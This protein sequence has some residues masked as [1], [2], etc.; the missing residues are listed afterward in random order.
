MRNNKYNVWYY[1]SNYKFNS[2]FIK[3]LFIIFTA[4][5]LPL[6]AICLGLYIY[7][8]GAFLNEMTASEENGLMRIKEIVD[9]VQTNILA[10]GTNLTSDYYIEHF[11]ISEQWDRPSYD[12]A[13]NIYNAIKTI[14]F[15]CGEYVDSIYIYS[16]NNKYVL[17]KQ[18][19]SSVTTFY[20]TLWLNSYEQ[21]RTNNVQWSWGRLMKTPSGKTLSCISTAF[22][23]PLVRTSNSIYG[24]VIVNLSGLWLDKLLA[25]YNDNDFYIVDYQG[26]ILYNQDS[27]LLGMSFEETVGYEL[28]RKESKVS[29][30]EQELRGYNCIRSDTNGWYYVMISGLSGY[31]EKIGLLNALI[32]TL[33]SVLLLLAVV[34]SYFISARVFLPIKN[35]MQMI[36]DPKTFYERNTAI[37]QDNKD[38]YNE[39][40]YIATS[41]LSSFSKTEQTE[42]ELSAISPS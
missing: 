19:P 23:M 26:R 42:A 9:T 21:N 1:F 31:Q 29:Y 28:K 37:T 15:S 5:Y 10:A 24:V 8:K 17:S 35:I 27:G 25:G 30:Y 20:D 32:W 4:I 13:R 40:L 3:N 36:D 6:A 39:F 22:T 33:L 16:E 2:L 7:F 34:V 11:I 38:R 14:T 12:V 18:S 41:F